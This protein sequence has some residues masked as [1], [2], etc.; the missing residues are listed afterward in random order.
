[1]QSRKE[2]LMETMDLYF[3]HLEIVA[4]KLDE[5]RLAVDALPKSVEQQEIMRLHFKSLEDKLE[6]IAEVF[7]VT[8]IATIN[9]CG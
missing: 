1:M 8:G 9:R 3:D 6:T 7:C 5:I 4:K 2:Y